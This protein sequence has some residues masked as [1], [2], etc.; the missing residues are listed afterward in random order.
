M[1]GHTRLQGHLYQ[2]H[3]IRDTLQRIIIF[4]HQSTSL[5]IQLLNC[6]L[7]Q[8][9][10]LTAAVPEPLLIISGRMIHQIPILPLQAAQYQ[11]LF[12]SE[13]TTR[14][15]KIPVNVSVIKYCYQQQ[16]PVSHRLSIQ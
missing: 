10:H 14:R 2:V 6:R 5:Q 13:H 16:T 9:L 12:R 4:Q 15:I 3:L 11:V 1:E 8:R 7:L